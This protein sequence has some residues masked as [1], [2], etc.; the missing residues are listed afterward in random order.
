MPNDE[1]PFFMG[2][3]EIRS[4]QQACFGAF[5]K[6][7]LNS[8][9]LMWNWPW[10][11]KELVGLSMA[12]QFFICLPPSVISGRFQGVLGPLNEATIT[13]TVIETG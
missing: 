6:A 7:I 13:Q 2:H 4:N 5:L 11:W 12:L 10:T 3:V 8:V 1:S 9:E